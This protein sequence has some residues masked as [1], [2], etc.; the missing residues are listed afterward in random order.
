MLYQIDV[1]QLTRFHEFTFKSAA[2]VEKRHRTVRHESLGVVAKHWQRR[3]RARRDHVDRL[4]PSSPSRFNPLRLHDCRRARR[5]DGFAEERTFLLVRFDEVNAGTG[6]ASNK[7][8]DNETR[9]TGAAS[10]V[11]PAPRT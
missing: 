10:E 6:A 9:K 5:A 4:T 2:L 3:Q 11:E 7:N 8:G 1:P